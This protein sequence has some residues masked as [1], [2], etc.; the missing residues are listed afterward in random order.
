MACGRLCLCWVIWRE[1]NR[2]IFEEVEND[3]AREE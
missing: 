2:G 1:R 3:L